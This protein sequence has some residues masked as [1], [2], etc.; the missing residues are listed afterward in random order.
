LPGDI[1]N[2]MEPWMSP[3]YENISFLVGP[4]LLTAMK[5]DGLLVI[6]PLSYMRGNTFTRDFIIVDEAQNVTHKQMEMIVTRLGK[7]SKMV[8][9][10]DMRQKDLPFRE[11][12]G[13]PFLLTVADKISKIGQYQLTNNHRNPL[14]EE[15]LDYYNEYN[16]SKKQE[17]SP[18]PH[19]K[20][21]TT[22]IHSTE[23]HSVYNTK[24]HSK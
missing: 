16:V 19:Y 4:D 7:G 5:A 20:K 12:S 11:S 15:I 14:V 17:N 1:D 3:I 21:R 22:I 23:S 2:K 24:Q 13:L 10:G 8:I 18:L 6:K 9:C